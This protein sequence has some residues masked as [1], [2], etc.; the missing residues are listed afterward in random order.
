M[1]ET[2]IVAIIVLGVI[3]GLLYGMGVRIATP[4][5]PM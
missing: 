5:C 2:A 3:G 4:K 1:L